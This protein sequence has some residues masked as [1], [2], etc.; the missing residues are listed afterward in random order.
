MR[1][2]PV[3]PTAAALNRLRFTAT[4]RLAVAQTPAVPV[5]LMGRRQL[6]HPLRQPQPELRRD[7]QRLVGH[8]ALQP[9]VLLL[10]RIQTLGLVLLQRPVLQPPPMERLLAPRPRATAAGEGRAGRATAVRLP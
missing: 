5:A 3:A 1:P 8:D 6:L 4:P 9:R 10:K 7:V 2:D